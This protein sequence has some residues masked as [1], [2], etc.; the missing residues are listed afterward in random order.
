MDLFTKP[1]ITYHFHIRNSSQGLNYRYSCCEQ[2]LGYDIL[3]NFEF[4]KTN[5]YLLT[6]NNIL[7]H[8]ATKKQGGVSYLLHPAGFYPYRLK[9]RIIVSVR[10]SG[11][12]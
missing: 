6:K 5:Q 11:H 3:K 12:R 4:T 7:G 2:T 9:K 8:A 1:S 10:S